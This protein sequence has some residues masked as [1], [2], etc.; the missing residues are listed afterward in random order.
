MGK[1]AT[2]QTTRL[3]EDLPEPLLMVSIRVNFHDHAKFKTVED[4]AS[5]LLVCFGGESNKDLYE[6]FESQFLEKERTGLIFLDSVLK[7]VDDTLVSQLKKNSLLTF[8]MVPDVG[9]FICSRKG[10]YKKVFYGTDDSNP[11]DNWSNT[12]FN[13]TLFVTTPACAK[14]HS[15]K[16]AKKS[17]NDG[18]REFYH[19]PANKYPNDRVPK[20]QGCITK[21]RA[22]DAFI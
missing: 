9:H 20:V 2:S 3:Q 12:V 19:L 17:G 7:F 1:Y 10:N 8:D 18:T 22:D 5:K 13:S 14:M 4:T 6:T 21:M 15:N 11:N 16:F